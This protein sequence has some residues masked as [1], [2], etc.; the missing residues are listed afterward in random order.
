MP[1]EIEH[2]CCPA[3]PV[4]TAQWQIQREG[5]YCHGPF[6]WPMKLKGTIFVIRETLFVLR[7]ISDIKY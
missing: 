3:W 5:T 2:I 6:L 7:H 1:M 4:A